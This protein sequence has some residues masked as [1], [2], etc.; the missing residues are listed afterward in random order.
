M[1]KPKPTLIIL[2]EPLGLLGLGVLLL[3]SQPV[4]PV[5]QF[6]TGTAA[7]LFLVAAATTLLV[8]LK[9]YL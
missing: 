9:R 1:N 6:I 5:I 3:V 7:G 2:W 8:R 4:N